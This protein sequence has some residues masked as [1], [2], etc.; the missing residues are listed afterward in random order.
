[1]FE[2]EEQVFENEKTKGIKRCSVRLFSHLLC[3]GLIFYV[4][5]LVISIA[6]EV[7]V[8]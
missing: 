7:R 1:M 4:H 3:R 6:D 2:N 5:I 8:I